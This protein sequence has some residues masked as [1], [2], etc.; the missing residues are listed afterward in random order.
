M[1]TG[2]FD[3][4]SLCSELQTKAKCGGEGPVIQEQEFQTTLRKYLGDEFMTKC[5][6]HVVGEY[7]R[8]GR[9]SQGDLP[10]EQQ[11]V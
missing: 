6:N 10:A 1:Q 8:E 3:L 5:G 9:Q 11:R 4:D 7:R 2:G